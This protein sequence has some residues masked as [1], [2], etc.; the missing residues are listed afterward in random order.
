MHSLLA[1]P[2]IAQRAPTEYVSLLSSFSSSSF[3]SSSSRVQ[4]RASDSLV[5]HLVTR[6]PF[7]GPDPDNEEIRQR[8]AALEGSRVH[9]SL[10]RFASSVA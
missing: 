10:L 8:H 5:H 4:P 3:S 7:R 2:R 1:A 6:R 9:L